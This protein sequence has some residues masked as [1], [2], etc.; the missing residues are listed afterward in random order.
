MLFTV[1]PEQISMRGRYSVSALGIYLEEIT[2][3]FP[4]VAADEVGLAPIA[5]PQCGSRLQSRG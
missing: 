1:L 4:I 2:A 5:Q 3:F